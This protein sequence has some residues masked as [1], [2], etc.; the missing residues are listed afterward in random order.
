MPPLHAITVEVSG[1][2]DA[3]FVSDVLFE[4]GALSV[5][6]SDLHQ[7]THAEDPIYAEPPQDSVTP[8]QSRA[9]SFWS[10]ARI[11]ALFPL[12]VDREAILMTIATDFRLPQSPTLHMYSE[13]F[14][15]NV[16][17]EWVAHAQ[18][19]FRPIVLGRAAIIF[20]RHPQVPGVLNVLLEAGMAFGTG[21]HAT[22]QLCALW[23]LETVSPG[24]EVLDYGAGSGV[25][26]ILAAVLEDDVTAVGVDIDP[27]AV[28][29]ARS[30]AARN[31]VEKRVCFYTNLA[32]PRGRLYDMVVA[33]ILAGPLKS[34]ADHLISKIKVGG[35]IALSSLLLSQAEDLTEWYNRR[36][37]VMHNAA[38]DSEWVLL[39]GTKT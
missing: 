17:A 19:S 21:E 35:Q 34:L 11:I 39:V 9:P 12:S 2:S 4:L 22:T 37:V 1:G 29:V 32:E 3:A 13:Q 10:D 16:P 38:V 15:D 31:G 26:A 24:T 20:P 5:S 18:V 25:L 28:K 6:T 27:D 7:G 36:G 33:N 14:K 23:L 8:S 30:N